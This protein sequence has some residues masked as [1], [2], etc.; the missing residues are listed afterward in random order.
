[1]KKL[2]LPLLILLTV[3]C[4][5][6]EEVTSTFWVNSFRSTCDA[7]AGKMQ[8]LLIDKSDSISGNWNYFYSNI[9]NFNYQEGYIYQIKVKVDT[10]EASQTPADAS[11]IQYTL[12]EVLSKTFD[13][14]TILNDIWALETI[15]G[16]TIELNEND[17]RPRLEISIRDRRVIG[18]DGCNNL[19]GAISELT[20]EKLV[21][22]SVVSTEKACL[23]APPYEKAFPTA[24]VLTT[25][26]KIEGTTLTL[27]DKQGNP[28][29]TF[30][31]V[32]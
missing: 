30:R 29:A 14:K 13:K 26:Y 20:E 12:A 4:T 2:I 25:H 21:V 23:N 16:E 6:E 28:T 22:T 17:E 31:K 7:G 1:M 5:P 24:L 18:F 15:Q 8:C 3:A 27:I 10:L 32:D 11:N 9:Q 19:A